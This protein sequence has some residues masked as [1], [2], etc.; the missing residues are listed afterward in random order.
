MHLFRPLQ[1]ENLIKGREDVSSETVV[2]IGNGALVN[3]WMP[4]RRVLDNWIQSSEH[5]HPV[6]NKLRV[7]NSEA[8]HQLAGLSYK[9]KI[10]RGTIYRQWQSGKMTPDQTALA[11]LGTSIEEF[12]NIRDQVSRQ[13][14]ISSGDLILNNDERVKKLLGNNAVYITTNWDN[15]L[16][17]DDNVRK[18]IYLHGRCDFSDS[19]VFPTE[20]IIEDIAY[21]CDKL[22][23]LTKNCSDEFRSKI[24]K[25]FRCSTVDALLSAHTIASKLIHQAKRLIIWGYS[26][27]DFDADINAIIGNNINREQTKEL[28]VINTDPYAFQRAVALTGLTQAWHFDPNLGYTLKLDI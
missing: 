8:M 1:E 16:W 11:G 7:Q 2:M 19:L 24:F 28:I 4:L 21:D 14:R 26:L 27:G 13:Y 23:E 20:L 15:A 10:A 18:A 9:F 22:L 5:S 25:S 6:I 17:L 3:G 12:L